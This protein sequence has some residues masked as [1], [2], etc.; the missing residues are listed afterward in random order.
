ME[1]ID[2]RMV[3][4]NVNEYDLEKLK[5][6][7]ELSITDVRCNMDD[8]E[9][10]L[11]E[12]ES[13][14]LKELTI[15]NHNLENLPRNLSK[16]KSIQTLSLG[17]T[18]LTSLGV[19]IL[20]S[21]IRYL[22]VFSSLLEYI[23]EE[24]IDHLENLY[25]LNINAPIKEVGGISKLC[26]LSFISLKNTEIE[27]ISSA[28]LSR[29]IST[30]ELFENSKL[31]FVDVEYFKKM[32]FFNLENNFNELRVLG[33]KECKS[34]R[35]LDMSNI[36][37]FPENLEYCLKLRVF[38]LKNSIIEEWP[39]LKDVLWRV[40]DLSINGTNLKKLSDDWSLFSNLE[41]L[42]LENNQ[43]ED[44]T[45]L[46][47]VPPL[48]S[49][50]NI[51][52]NPMKDE[53]FM[54]E[55][56]KTLLCWGLFAFKA[57]DSHEISLF[58]SALAKSG[59]SREDKEWFFYTIKD[60]LPNDI[61]KEWPLFRLLQGLNVPFKVIADTTLSRLQELE[62]NKKSYESFTKGS[63][64]FLD[65]NF[66]EN[67][68][69]IKDKLNVLGISLSRVLNEKVTHVVLGKK[70]KQALEYYNKSEFNFILEHQ[71]YQVIKKVGEE[72]MF[73]IQEASE[74]ETVMQE[75]VKQ[76][77]RST[78]PTSVNLGIEMLKS[79]GFTDEILEEFLVLS[80]TFDDSKVRADIRKLLE[81][82]GVN[83]WFG[84]LKDKHT[85]AGIQNIEE[86]DIRWK[87][88]KMLKFVSEEEVYQFAKLL[89]KYCYKGFA[90]VL[91]N[92]PLNSEHRKHALL[93]LT[94]GNHLDFH[95]GVG[96]PPNRD[97]LGSGQPRINIEFPSDHPNLKQ[98]TK[99][100][101]HDC[102]F[103]SL[104]ENIVLFENIEELDLSY[105]YLKSLP[106]EISNLSKLRILNL[107]FNSITKFPTALEKLE[108]LEVLDLRCSDYFSFNPRKKDIKIPS[109]F[110]EK[111]PNCKVLL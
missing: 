9:S 18:K 91:G 32:N 24:N 55:I 46:Q 83:Q 98:I 86:S 102:K 54:L 50:F 71:L 84:I 97:H 101:M 31:K 88:E 93:S 14:N 59:L 35:Y 85:F 21:N 20:P 49:S 29:D 74:G 25:S 104:S 44:F 77:L 68:N 8:I 111:L 109:S 66:V 79:G 1:Y 17:L 5:A 90:F 105:N 72:D 10:L 64:C 106:L 107:S 80:K 12:C 33:L 48:K 70:P 69:E 103:S 58:M 100:D 26:K 38:R 2:T 96:Y 22:N 56:K 51:K 40:S 108:S 60:N 62:L 11:I 23:S 16:L 95:S 15:S 19:R 6:A 37:Y 30:L 73:L 75:G 76:L 82:Q 110:T 45:F 53:L 39:N 65:G 81:K 4:E 7:T 63:V 67:K 42:N 57:L 61:I 34:L 89:M 36:K 52:G 28:C 43:I 94:K 47:F 41:F 99:I 13:E 92:Y 78:D 87:L 27:S 3:I